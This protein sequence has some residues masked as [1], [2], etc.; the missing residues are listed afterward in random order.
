MVH[1]FN[2][3]YDFIFQCDLDFVKKK[4]L[5]SMTNLF[6]FL[7]KIPLRIIVHRYTIDMV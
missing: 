1:K 7:K 5:F 3:K 2:M 6:Y 4:P